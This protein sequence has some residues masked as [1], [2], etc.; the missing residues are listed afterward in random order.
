M[1]DA[2]NRLSDI[3]FVSC[4]P[5]YCSVPG[6][7]TIV[8]NITS[9]NSIT[10]LPQFSQVRQPESILDRPYRWKQ[11]EKDM[12]NAFSFNSGYR[13]QAYDFC[14]LILKYAMKRS[15]TLNAT[16]LMDKVIFSAIYAILCT[17]SS[18]SAA[19]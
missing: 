6:N 1:P 7:V 8:K 11:F 2:L 12:Q 19:R 10:V 17:P 18:L 15:T 14:N 9:S 5:S 3:S 13:L 16:A 4:I